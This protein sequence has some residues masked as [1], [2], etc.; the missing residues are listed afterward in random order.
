[1]DIETTRVAGS[2]TR[3]YKLVKLP[4]KKGYMSDELVKE[5]LEARTQIAELKGCCLDYPNPML[6]LSPAIVKESLASSEIERIHT[7]LIDV[8][9]NAL[10]PEAE[11]KAADKEVLRYREAVL[12][13]YRKLEK[14]PV[15]AESLVI[16]I[17]GVLMQ[18]TGE[19][20]RVD[21]NAIINPTTRRVVFVPPKVSDIKGLIKN[22][23]QY[24]NSVPG[25][26][27][28]DDP[29]IRSAIAH[30]QFESIHPFVDG[31][32]RAGRIL[33]ILQLIRAGLLTMPILYISGYINKNK[34]EYYELLRGVTNKGDWN[35]YLLFMIRGF[36]EQAV[37]TKELLLETRKLFNDTKRKIKEKDSKLYSYELLDAIFSVPIINATALSKLLDV[38][39]ITAGGY[40]KKLE[41]MGVLRSQ[42]YGKYVMYGNVQL[43][44]LLNSQ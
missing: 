2:K 37:K 44:D 16:G 13:A 12:Y 22:W 7:T 41:K 4:P 14:K 29:L 6:L 43:L 23:E 24:V 42:R 11:R 17:H 34:T 32:G 31:N 1:M 33:M 25:T 9:Q 39:H 36:K 19:G 28:S 27:L 10:L 8:F 15:I 18:V 26:D 3:P 30:Y 40:L 21:Q 35:S 20:F 38:H 5:L